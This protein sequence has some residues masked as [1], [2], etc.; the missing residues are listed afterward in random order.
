MDDPFVGKETIDYKSVAKNENCVIATTKY[1]GH[2]GYFESWLS[3]KMS[4]L[5][6]TFAFLD[7]F[8]Q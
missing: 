1:G 2:L 8:D 6:P 3:E 7:T 5:E 4:V